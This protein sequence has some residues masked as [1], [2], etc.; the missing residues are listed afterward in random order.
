[1]YFAAAAPAK[2]LQLG[3]NSQDDEEEPLSPTLRGLAKL[4]GA[5]EESIV[6]VEAD[7]DAELVAVLTQSELSVWSAKVRSSR[8]Y[9]QESRLK[10]P[11]AF[12]PC[13]STSTRSALIAIK[14]NQRQRAMA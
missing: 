2:R 5:R 10:A 3:T 14:W 6:A 1:M 11:K 8:L 12:H 13:L 7:A 4:G 9:Q